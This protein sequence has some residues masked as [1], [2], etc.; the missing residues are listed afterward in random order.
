MDAKL[1]SVMDEM[2]PIVRERLEHDGIAW[3]RKGEWAPFAVKHGAAP[4]ALSIVHQS[5]EKEL[6]VEV[7]EFAGDPKQTLAIHRLLKEH[8]DW[9]DAARDGFRQEFPDVHAN[10]PMIAGVKRKLGLA[11]ALGSGRMKEPKQMGA[12][13]DVLLLL[14]PYEKLIERRA[15]IDA[16]IDELKVELEVVDEELLPYKPLKHALESLRAAAARVTT[17][18]KERALRERGPI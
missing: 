2:L 16:Q 14:N 7:W 4:R 3:Q 12:L 9:N 17:E 18:Q 5:I 1:Q 6:G 11:P 15:A 8:G 13:K 10:G